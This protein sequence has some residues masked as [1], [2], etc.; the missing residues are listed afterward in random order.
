MTIRAALLLL[1]MLVAV[2]VQSQQESWLHVDTDA[3]T[4]AVMRGDRVLKEF[5]DISI[6]RGG[7]SALRVRDDATTPLGVFHILWINTDSMYHRFYGF[8]YPTLEQATPAR[9]QGL[10]DGST[11][12]AI[13]TALQADR[14]PPQNTPLGGNLGIHG[15]GNGDMRI[16]E[17]FNWTNGCIAL[18]NEQIDAL[19]RWVHVGMKVVV[20]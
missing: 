16:H 2:P 3:A 13:S 5:D 1:C 14:L 17:A 9:E 20:Y 10:I 4:L 8:N 6:G 7:T 11:Y 19:D 15:V 12:Q 18:T